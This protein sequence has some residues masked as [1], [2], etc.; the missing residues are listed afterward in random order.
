M[1]ELRADE[2]HFF[3]TRVDEL[4]QDPLLLESYQVVVNEAEKRK[5]NRYVFEKDRHR[6]L[7]TRALLRYVLSMCTGVDPRG[8]D[9]M[10]NRYGKPDLKPGLVMVPLS[11]NLSHSGGITACAV[12]LGH[13]IGV[14][15]EDCRRKTDVAIADRF[16]SVSEADSIKQCPSEDRQSAFYDFWTL[17]ESYIKAR[18][19][20][21]SIDLKH[22]SFSIGTPGITIDFDPSLNDS[23]REWQF[24]RFSPVEHY[25]AA[26][27]IRSS[28]ETPMA[29]N[30]Y[31]CIPFRSME[32][33]SRL[34]QGQ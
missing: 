18:G 34:I 12:A 2:T 22:F 25:K 14:D 11:F 33:V 19:M 8:F 4:K 24:F 3:Y 15:V 13:D 7:V 27:A 17:K 31:S 16:F 26:I 21:L 10:E 29:L 30:V 1:I 32:K 28:L 9:F 5:V 23:S 20:G 6:S